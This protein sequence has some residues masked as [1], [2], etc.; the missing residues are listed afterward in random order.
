MHFRSDHWFDPLNVPSFCKRLYSYYGAELSG[1]WLAVL[2]RAG[3]CAEPAHVLGS[4]GRL[5]LSRMEAQWHCKNLKC[6][7]DLSPHVA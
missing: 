3:L 1:S 2:R 6:F 4:Y 7:E 5:Y